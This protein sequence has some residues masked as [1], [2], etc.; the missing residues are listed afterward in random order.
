MTAAF[1]LTIQVIKKKIKIGESI[2]QLLT[3]NPNSELLGEDS[4]NGNVFF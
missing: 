4:F 3:K 1:I 2:F